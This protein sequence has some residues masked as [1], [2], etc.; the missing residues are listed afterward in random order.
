MA[1]GTVSR[2]LRTVDQGGRPSRP[3]RSPSDGTIQYGTARH[4]TEGG[5]QRYD[6]LL[7]RPPVHLYRTDRLKKRSCI[8]WRAC[9]VGV[10][11]I[12]TASVSSAT[13]CLLRI[14]STV[15]GTLGRQAGIYQGV[16]VHA[17]VLVLPVHLQYPL[18]LA[19]VHRHQSPTLSPAEARPGP[20]AVSA[21]CCSFVRLAGCAWAGSGL[22][23]H[24][25]CC[26]V[27]TSI[28]D[29]TLSFSAHA[30]PTVTRRFDTTVQR[31][32]PSATEHH[33]S[34]KAGPPV[35][36]WPLLVLV[37]VLLLDW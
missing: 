16:R 3:I 26:T 21:A 5:L 6:G 37:L 13:T 22:R 25:Q 15:P 2:P 11:L 33:H 32:C 7:L 28:T 9:R 27:P 18:L 12:M 35:P 19:P 17:Q 36:C 24:R 23:S 14:H 34:Q 1:S 10:W 4:S 29:P 31:I 30:N 8:C 20:S